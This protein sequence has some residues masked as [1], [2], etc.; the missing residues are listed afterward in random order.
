MPRPLHTNAQFHGRTYQQFVD[1]LHEPGESEPMLSPGKY[2]VALRIALRDLAD[3]AR[4]HRNTVSRSPNSKRVQ[5]YLRQALRVI[6]AGT[7]LRGD[8][9]V[10]LLW[11]R[12]EPLAVFDYKTAE[13]LVAERRTDDVLRYVTSI[14]A[15]AAG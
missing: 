14:E 8:V 13:A 9:N 1:F 2:A 4:V 5:E 6:K 11:Y 7:D 12:G 15:G 10:A 3:Q